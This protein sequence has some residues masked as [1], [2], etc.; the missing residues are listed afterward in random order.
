MFRGREEK[1][2]QRGNTLPYPLVCEESDIK[3][4]KLHSYIYFKTYSFWFQLTAFKHE[5]SYFVYLTFFGS[6]LR[7]RK[8]IAPMSLFNHWFRIQLIVSRDMVNFISHPH[9]S[10]TNLVICCKCFPLNVFVTVYPI[11]IH[12]NQI[13]LALKWVKV[14][15][16]SLFM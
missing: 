11:Q 9:K 15:P 10:S 7:N 8:F 4:T 5:S 3:L 13:D 1:S 12:T 16:G 2:Q 6:S 14:N